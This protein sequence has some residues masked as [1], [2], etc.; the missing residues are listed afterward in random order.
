M[1]VKI[2]SNN[3][4]PIVFIIGLSGSGKSTLGQWVQ[5]D[6][7]FLHIEHDTPGSDIIDIL[8]IR[9]EWD[10]YLHNNNSLELG[11]SLKRRARQVNK[12]GV[13]MTFTSMVRFSVE[14]IKCAEN[15]GIITRILYG[16]DEDCLNSYLEREKHMDRGY[17]E[18]RWIGYN[19]KSYELFSKPEY[20]PYREYA[21]EHHQRKPRAYLVK[22]IQ[23]L[24]LGP[25]ISEN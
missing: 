17:D 3:S 20:V 13:I 9:N 4:L 12:Q 5:N 21:F 6:L 2:K 14:N 25:D 23:M 24:A 11:N 22:R 1:S 16:S 19:T 18:K 15:A 8:G 10:N 7:N